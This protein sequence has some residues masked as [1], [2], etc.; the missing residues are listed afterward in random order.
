MPKSP[1][2]TF[3]IK[4]LRELVPATVFFAIGFNLIVLSTDL[5]NPGSFGGGKVGADRECDAILAPFRHGP[6]DPTYPVQDGRPLGSR[7]PGPVPGKAN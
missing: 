4:E 2:L 3:V 1:L 6:D 5:C 7:F